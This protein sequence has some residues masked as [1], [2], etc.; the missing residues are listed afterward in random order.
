MIILCGDHIITPL[1]I[2]FEN[3]ISTRIFPDGWK[4]ANVVP[5]HKKESKLLVKNYRPISLLPICAK[6]FKKVLFKHLYNYLQT[7]NLITK[8]KSD[9]RPGDSTTNQLI[10]FVNEIQRSF[11]NKNS[12][13]VRSM[14]LDFKALDK[15]WHDGLIFKLK[16]N[17]IDGNLLNFFSSYLQNRKQL[18]VLNCSCSEWEVIESGVPQGSVLG[19]LLFLHYINDLEQNIKSCIKFFAD[20]TMLYSIILDERI[21]AADF[22][23]GHINGKWL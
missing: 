18:V 2:I 12:L 23:I 9:F 20:D 22:K 8:M 13:E 17:G 4:I 11:D 1:R 19:P 16:Q 7:N 6:I 15:V 3:I 21:S 10:D 14:F 5:V